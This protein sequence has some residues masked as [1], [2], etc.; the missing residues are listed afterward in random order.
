MSGS[1]SPKK[2]YYYL[3]IYVEENDKANVEKW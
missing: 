3:C 2:Y 1:Y